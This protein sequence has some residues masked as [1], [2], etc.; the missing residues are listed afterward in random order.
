MGVGVGVIDDVG[1][2]DGL[3]K[4]T[5]TSSQVSTGETAKL[6]LAHEVYGPVNIAVV[7]IVY[8]Y[9]PGLEHGLLTYTTS[10][11]CSLPAYVIE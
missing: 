1:V 8:P 6:Q 10:K 3:G 7:G 2:G 11:H 9:G 5:K 4:G